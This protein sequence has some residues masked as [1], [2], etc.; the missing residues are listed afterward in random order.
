MDDTFTFVAPVMPRRQIDPFA[1]RLAV[2]AA[3]ALIAT[4]AFATFVIRHEH[5]ADVQRTLLQH[6]VERADAARAAY[7][8]AQA[9]T[10]AIT[11]DQQAR[12]SADR[13]VALAR[14]VIEKTSI[15][16]DA[17]PFQLSGIQPSL[18][19]VDGP[20]TSPGV[21]SIA[22]TDAAWAAAVKGPSGACYWVRLSADGETT[23]GTGRL[24]TGTSAMT[25]TDAAW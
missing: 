13:A 3:V 19:F 8:T 10:A 24:C 16:S 4:V 18:L 20:S 22:T 25:A 1:W 12:D 5:V 23:Y 11:L 9:D 6:Q 2:T 21:V 7:V 14:G 17:G 15:P